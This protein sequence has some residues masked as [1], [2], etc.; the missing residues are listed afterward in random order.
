MIRRVRLRSLAKVNLD[1]RVLHK[2]G[3][4]FHELRTVFQ[5]ISLADTIVIEYEPARRTVLELDD[6]LAIPDNLVLRAARAA[7]D[8][9]KMH[10]RVR[11]RLQKR[12]PIGGGLGGGSSN[13]AAVLLALPV[14][15]GHR[16]PFD[17]LLSLGAELGS[18]VPFFL[19][20]GTAVAIGR[21]TEFYG[22]PEVA[23]EPMLVVASGIHV[24]TGPAYA[25]LARGLTS[26]DFSRKISAFRLFVR[27]LGDLRSA[28]A[29]S[30]LSANDFESPVFS[31]QPLLKKMWGR[32]RKHAAGA[33]M[34]GSGSALFGVF[35]SK[36]ERDLAAK[37]LEGD[38]VF[39]D[40]RVVPASLV[41]GSSYRRLWRRQLAEYIE[42]PRTPNEN[43]WPPHSRHAA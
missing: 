38:G 24:A 20:G 17:R 42:G 6:P 31:Q 33:R 34:T 3:D 35:G 7:L 23:A 15:A 4:G 5:T 39:E 22:L 40:C 27:T 12:I 32:L 11:F 36:A 13:A 26:P 16:I 30:T 43:L 21:G 41:S 18:D 37:T 28:R 8:A 14:M 10:A 19:T 29:A 9:M 2:R 1:L 25:A